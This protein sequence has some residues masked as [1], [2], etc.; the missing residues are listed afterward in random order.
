MLS[1]MGHWKIIFQRP[2]LIMY[3]F[4]TPPLKL[5]LG[6]Q[7]GGGLLIANHL[8]QSVWCANQRYWE[9]LRSYLLHSSLQVKGAVAP[10]TS[11][12][13]VH[14]SADPKPA[15]FTFLHRNVLCRIAYWAPPWRCS[16]GWVDP[17]QDC[18]PFFVNRNFDFEMKFSLC[19]RE[20]AIRGT[21]CG[22]CFAK[23]NTHP[24]CLATIVKHHL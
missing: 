21:P 23:W 22:G 2:S 4:A 20:P 17:V 19:T 1:S 5:K 7:I 11:H 15:Y 24:Q 12:S 18:R 16:K 14:N 13:K 9:A 10:F 8:G 6:Q 3:S